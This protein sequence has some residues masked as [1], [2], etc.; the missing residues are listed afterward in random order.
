[1]RPKRLGDIWISRNFFPYWTVK[2]SFPRV[3]RHW[4]I[5]LKALSPRRPV[6]QYE[7]LLGYHPDYPPDGLYVMPLSYHINKLQRARDWVYI[8]SWHLNAVESA[9]MWRLYLKSDEGI[10]VQSTVDR[11][12]SCFHQSQE[13]ILLGAMKYVDYEAVNF[14][15]YKYDF[16]YFL[17]N[18]SSPWAD[19]VLWAL[20]KR[21]SFAHEREL[22][23]II[24]HP[25][26]QDLSGICVNVDPDLLIERIYVAPTAPEWISDLVRSVTRKYGLDVEVVH[27][28]LACR[29]LY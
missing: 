12:R 25:E 24:V 23:A 16:P 19:P 20:H 21:S 1:M 26:R 18:G 14:M 4:M 10:A 7:S 2:V 6:A 28:T 29:P 27:S 15:D 17:S 22:R 13:E 9:A 5:S 8:S 11:M 3:Y